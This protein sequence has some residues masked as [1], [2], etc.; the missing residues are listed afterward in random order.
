M[1]F[2]FPIISC[3]LIRLRGEREREANTSCLP[4]TGEWHRTVVTAK[5]DRPQLLCWG[6]FDEGPPSGGLKVCKGLSRSTVRVCCW[7]C[8]PQKELPS[9]ESTG[10]HPAASF[11]GP[12]RSS[13]QTDIV[14]S[15]TEEV[16]AQCQPIQERSEHLSTTSESSNG[17][18][19]IFG[20]QAGNLGSTLLRLIFGTHRHVW[21]FWPNF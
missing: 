11:F 15:T 6:P 1:L 9:G 8:S 7:P 20:T 4:S 17:H 5:V 2:F 16:V 12:P 13:K 18:S 21:P 19:D 14:S 3:Y 10:L